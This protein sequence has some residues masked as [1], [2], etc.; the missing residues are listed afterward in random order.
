[1][2]DEASAISVGPQKER[3]YEKDI[4]PVMR[5]APSIEN[6]PMHCGRRVRHFAWSNTLR[7]E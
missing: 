7:G 3:I 1:M 5:D 6:H 4:R 2:I